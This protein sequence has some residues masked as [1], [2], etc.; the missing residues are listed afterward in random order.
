M[1]KAV[2]FLLSLTLSVLANAQV[3]GVGS[4]T[5]SKTDYFGNTVTTHRDSY[6]RVTGTSTTSK[7][8]YFGNTTTTHRDSYG[9]V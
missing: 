1:K 8:D 5:T 7:T 3:Y 9:N 2:I 6:G 4:S